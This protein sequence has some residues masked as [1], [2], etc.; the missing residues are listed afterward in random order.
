ME[1]QHPSSFLRTIIIIFFFFIGLNFSL[2]P[3]IEF[4]KLLCSPLP[5]LCLPS[6]L[7]MVLKPKKKRGCEIHE[8]HNLNLLLLKLTR[9]FISKSIDMSI[10]YKSS[11]WSFSISNC[12]TFQVRK[13]KAPQNVHKSIE[14]LCMYC[15]WNALKQ[16]R[17]LV[18]R[19]GTSGRWFLLLVKKVRTLFWVIREMMTKMKKIVKISEFKFSI[20]SDF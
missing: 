12:I 18:T 8:S 7:S 15:I 10:W 20:F 9:Y 16:F 13:V 3:S 19:K 4:S 5:F 17:G 11:T 2:H 6:S 14:I 1:S